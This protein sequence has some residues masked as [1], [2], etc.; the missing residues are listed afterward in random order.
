MCRRLVFL[1]FLGVVLVIAANVSA[2]L[3]GHWK[4]DEGSGTTTADASGNG[5]NHPAT[6][7]GN[8]QWVSGKIGAA[9]EIRVC[10]ECPN[11]CLCY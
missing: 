4:L 8:P 7:I 2:E 1:I 5:N 3:V 9:L 11:E 6:L 10:A